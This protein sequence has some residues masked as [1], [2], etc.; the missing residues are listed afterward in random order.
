MVTLRSHATDPEFLA[1]FKEGI[2]LY[3]SGDWTNARLLLEKAD[4]QMAALAP[5]L[6][7]D[8]PSQTLLRYMGHQNF[9]PPSSWKG[10]R[11]LTSK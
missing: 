7:G 10:F 2:A 6:G 11:P 5:A 1:T 9:V 8:G 4:Q 3:L